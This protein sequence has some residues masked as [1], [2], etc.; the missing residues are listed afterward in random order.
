MA[1]S[2]K[3]IEKNR[4]AQGK[5]AS[6]KSK[7]TIID[8]AAV[9]KP[10]GSPAAASIKDPARPLSESS[11]QATARQSAGTGSQTL[12][13]V[14]AGIAVVIALLALAVSAVTFQQTNDI[15]SMTGSDQI[16]INTITDKNAVADLGQIAQ[17]LDYLEA[18][19]EAN[20]EKQLAFQREFAAEKLAGGVAAT[21]ENA[22]NIAMIN[23]YRIFDLIILL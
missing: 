4:F 20:T 21:L 16:G 5:S 19:T 2:K 12:A 9:E 17:R 18:V 14:F 13:P 3:P 10:T 11:G 1:E 15:I 7:Q 8:G 6:A 23:D 22:P